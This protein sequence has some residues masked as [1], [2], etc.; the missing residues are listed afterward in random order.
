MDDHPV[1]SIDL[2]LQNNDNGSTLSIITGFNVIVFTPNMKKSETAAKKSPTVKKIPIKN[3]FDA[4]KMV[5]DNIESET[6]QALKN[7]IK[8]LYQIRE[9][10]KKIPAMLKS[11]TIMNAKRILIDEDGSDDAENEMDETESGK[12]SLTMILMRICM[13]N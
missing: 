13:E 7:K 10:I 12:K 5:S 8:R 9:R 2:E 1:S 11:L 3:N 6:M 4:G